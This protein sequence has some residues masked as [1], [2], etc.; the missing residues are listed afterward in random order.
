MAAEL[1]DE[2]RWM[3]AHDKLRELIAFLQEG[4]TRE[5]WEV[6]AILMSVKGAM[7]LSGS[8]DRLRKIMAE[9][10]EKEL[11]ILNAGNN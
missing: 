11:Q 10:T 1:T 6:T 2:Q 4:Q 3:I 9:Y 5:E 8:L 7:H